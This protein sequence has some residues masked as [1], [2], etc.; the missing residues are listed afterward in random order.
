VCTFAQDVADPAVLRG[1][2][3][4]LAAEVA[5][6]ARQEAIAGWTLNLKIRFGGFEIHT[7]QRRLD[8]R[9]DDSRTLFGAAWSLFEAG[10]WAGMPVRLIRL[11]IADLGA[12]DRFQ[13][14]LFDRGAQRPV[15]NTRER[16]LTATLD[17][18]RAR[19]DSDP[20]RRGMSA[21]R[22]DPAADSVTR[23]HHAVG[24][25]P[26]A[27]CLQ[28]P[29]GRRLGTGTVIREKHGRQQTHWT[30]RNSTQ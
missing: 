29:G 9:S 25:L 4:D 10:R 8:R 2:L 13:P 15:D 6:A 20:L 17:R 30:Y 24:Y 27:P 14:D 23:A 26:A 16:R 19:F 3:R 22:E 1:T 18:I 11:G 5:A 21:A 28:P 12:P 7:R